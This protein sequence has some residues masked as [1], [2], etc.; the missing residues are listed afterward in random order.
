MDSQFKTELLF[1]KTEIKTGISMENNINVLR[2]IRMEIILTQI[3]RTVLILILAGLV[4]MSLWLVNVLKTHFAKRRVDQAQ[5]MKRSFEILA[6]APVRS[7]SRAPS[8][9]A[10]RT[11]EIIDV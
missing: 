9:T 1:Y 2:V 11:S 4:L 7:R 8:S 5:I 6:M 3:Y 10:A